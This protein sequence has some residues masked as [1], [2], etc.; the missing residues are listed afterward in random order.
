MG[1]CE[2]NLEVWGGGGARN[3]EEKMSEPRVVDR[4]RGGVETLRGEAARN[5]E[6]VCEQL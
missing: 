6:G 5:L 4:G 1:G 3:I 2:R